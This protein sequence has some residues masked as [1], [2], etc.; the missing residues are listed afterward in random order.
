MEEMTGEQVRNDQKYKEG[1]GIRQSTGQS[2]PAFSILYSLPLSL[3]RAGI[4][5]HQFKSSM[6]P[7]A[8]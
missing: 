2:L 6:I 1:T 7:I 5:P 8:P 3:R 4:Q